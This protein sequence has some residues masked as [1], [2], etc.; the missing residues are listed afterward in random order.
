MKRILITILII[1]IYTASCLSQNNIYSWQEYFSYKN[2]KNILEINNT[3]YCSTDNGLFYYDKNDY[4]INRLNKINGLSDVGIHKM[5]YD[6]YSNTIIIAYSN[7]NIDLIKE[8]GQVVNITDIKEKLITGKKK[9]NNI[10]FND[11]FAYLSCSFGLLVLDIN[12]E[13]IKDTY[14]IGSNGVFVEINDCVFNDSSIIVGTSNGSYFADINS[15]ALFD[16]NTWNKNPIHNESIINITITPSEI[17]YN[18]LSQSIITKYF[19]NYTI[20]FSENNVIIYKDDGTII[21]LENINFFNI[22]DVLIDRDNF[23]WIADSIN[24]LMK[25]EN[26]QLSNIIKPNGPESNIINKIKI[27]DNIMYLYHNLENNSISKSEDLIDWQ[28]WSYF[29]NSVCSEKIDKS[30]YVGSSTSGLSKKEG[31]NIINYTPGNTQNI[32]DTNY[33]IS[34]LISDI[35]KNLWGTISFSGKTLFVRTNNNFWSYYFMPELPNDR[36]IRGLIIDDYNQKWGIVQGKGMFVFNDNSTI[37]DKT[38]DQY[39]VITTS[40]GSG[41]LPN[42]EVY[43]IANDLDGDIWVGTKEGICV[44]YSP[45]SVFSGYNFDAQQIVVE[46]NGFGQY[47][48]ESEVVYAIEIDAGNRKWIGT[49]NSG[50]YLLSEDGR[51]EIYHF[52]VDNSPLPSNTILDITINNNNGLVF[53]LTDRGLV[54][55]K[56]DAT[57]VNYTTDKLSIYPNPIRESYYGPI[58]IN[59]LSYDSE[60]KITDI[61]GNLIYQTYSNGGTVVWDGND[62]NN[63]RVKTGVYLIFGSDVYKN[64]K[65]LGKILIIH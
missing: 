51:E 61:N 38:D 6:E 41:N 34:N 2:A 49:L 36:E 20:D 12:K 19:N 1:F 62:S 56:S 50:I 59:G 26:F 23:L 45:S 30:T 58:T 18:T 55:Y 9:I 54:S 28:I 8:N 22:Q 21:N 32:L 47:L 17:I 48:L 25:F 39:K 37:E 15:N 24:S 57:T 3:I 31:N 7:C 11:G 33:Y 16:Y 29:R 13:E 63:E 52:T 5:E 27:D 64:K 53:I 14:N 65:S 40:I 43:D 42:K 44:F 10:R 46:E 35:D 60:V 4:T